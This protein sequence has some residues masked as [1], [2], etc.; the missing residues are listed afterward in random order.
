M[1]WQLLVTSSIFW[2]S[3]SL[4]TFY[5]AQDD[6]NGRYPLPLV[7]IVQS[8]L[9]LFAAITVFLANK[10]NV[11]IPWPSL[12]RGGWL[13]FVGFVILYLVLLARL[14]SFSHF[15]GSVG[16]FS[17]GYKGCEDECEP[18][19]AF[20]LNFNTFGHVIQGCLSFFLFSDVKVGGITDRDGDHLE[21]TKVIK[22][23][24]KEVIAI[25]SC[26]YP[27]YNITKRA[28]MSA[29][30]FSTS[31]FWN[32]ASEWACGFAIGTC[33]IY[34]YYAVM[35][36]SYVDSLRFGNVERVNER[37]QLLPRVRKAAGIALIIVAL[38]AIIL[39]AAS[40]NKVESVPD[41][42][43]SADALTLL[44]LLILPSLVVTPL[45]LFR[46]S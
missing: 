22:L 27:I 45:V 8:G 43:G 32:N 18:N 1:S 25:S 37:Q 39:L 35:Y 33:A 6:P 28:V 16:S 9:L 31:S 24:I 23:Y 41:S 21:K 13:I 5:D 46:Y 30:T 12:D 29:K 15:G 10:A 34:A 40:W 36:S 4:A 3:M 42:R 20:T 2:F 44:V 19:E 11:Q 38:L 26:V 17:F 7:L 14:L